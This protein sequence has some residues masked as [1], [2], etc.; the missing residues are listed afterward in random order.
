MQT[1]AGTC[2]PCQQ[3][4]FYRT[5]SCTEDYICCTGSA[6]RAQCIWPEE[7]RCKDHTMRVHTAMVLSLPWLI[8]EGWHRLCLTSF[9]SLI[10]AVLQIIFELS[11][12]GSCCSNSHLEPRVKVS[13]QELP[14]V[15][16]QSSTRKN[17]W[18][19]CFFVQGSLGVPAGL[20]AR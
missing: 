2:S 16:Y 8:R 9:S 12:S 5:S 11:N 15:N 13:H 19:Y 14:L 3:L 20:R 1:G 17:K 4:Q 7:M 6:C 18:K 10:A